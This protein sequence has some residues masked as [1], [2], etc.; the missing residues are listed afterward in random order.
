M[1]KAT[2]Y[3]THTERVALI[4]A[5]E[6][7]AARAATDDALDAIEVILAEAVA[8]ALTGKDVAHLLVSAV[9]IADRQA[10]GCHDSHVQIVARL[11]V[12]RLDAARQSAR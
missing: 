5:P 10:P 12:R 6:R 3:P 7:V 2:T 1:K 4:N 9:A 11:Y 8:V